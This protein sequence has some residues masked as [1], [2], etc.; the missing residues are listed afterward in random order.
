MS[1]A[2]SER[3]GGRWRRGARIAF[4]LLSAPTLLVAAL[5]AV[6]Y[7]Q[8]GHEP[9]PGALPA[10]ASVTSAALAW[11]KQGKN[12]CGAYSLALALRV[13]GHEAEGADLVDV[14]SH[15]LSWSEALSGTLPWKIQGELSRRRLTRETFTAAGHPA[16]DRLGP[17]RAH[18][19]AGAPVL[20]LIESERGSQHYV[21]ALGYSSAGLDLYDP[22]FTPDPARPE[23]TL[24]DNGERPGN[25]TLSEA[26]VLELW[27]RGGGG[28][29]YRW[30][31]L[32]V[33]SLS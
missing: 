2:E 4:L 28:G 32:P 20:L 14:V 8:P 5:Y 6:L 31:Y 7:L 12:Q 16:Q 11:P 25:R 26:R 9:T 10:A 29:L 21:L 27:S 33:R 1:E 17:V 30:W 3:G 18:L 22:N 19:A 15:R 13:Y 23:V 24:D